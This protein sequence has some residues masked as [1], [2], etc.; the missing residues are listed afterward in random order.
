MVK[1]A[2][3]FVTQNETE[4]YFITLLRHAE[5]AGNAAGIWQG[6]ADYELSE[7]GRQQARAL[8]KRWSAEN[9]RFD[10]GICS[11][12]LRARQTASIITE[13]LGFP[14]EFE[15]EWL[16]R[17]NGR[18]SGLTQREAEALYPGPFF[19]S[20]Y[21]SIGETGESQ[22]ELYQ[23]AGRALQALM[24]R[25]PGRYVVIS[26]GGILNMV[27]YAILG[28][29][30]QAN[31]QGPRFSFENAAYANLVY[32]PGDHKWRVIS[33]NDRTHEEITSGE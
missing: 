3:M 27:L 10:L 32:Y 5:S 17:D 11:P 6:Q 21:E 14:V 31:F 2:A 16:E 22:W 23:R 13:Q 29:P 8:A 7:R 9:A 25:P 4:L 12:L 30:V 15:D 18:L 33:F 26:H 1:C 28:I 24:R 20:P 19:I